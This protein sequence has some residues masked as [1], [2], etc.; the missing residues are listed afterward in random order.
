[1]SFEIKFSPKAESTFD[2]LV[3]Q[4]EQRWGGKFVDKFKDKV[5]KT[6]DLISE[7]PYVYPIAPEN[8]ILRKCILHKNCSMLYRIYNDNIEII[9]FWDNRQDPMSIF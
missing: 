7:T 4:L 9:Y 6:L 3:T 2:D 8:S 1:M 5:S